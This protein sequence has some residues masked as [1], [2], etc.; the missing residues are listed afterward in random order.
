MTQN[1]KPWRRDACDLKSGRGN[2]G[3]RL[4]PNSVWAAALRSDARRGIVRA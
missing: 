1:Q 3:S 4:L 2:L